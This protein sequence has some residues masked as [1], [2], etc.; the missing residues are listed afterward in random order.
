MMCIVCQ[1]GYPEY[2]NLHVKRHMPRNKSPLKKRAG[3]VTEL[4]FSLVL[5]RSCKLYLKTIIIDCC[6][7]TTL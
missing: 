4:F 1:W 3:C 5:F 7:K 2:N 6:K